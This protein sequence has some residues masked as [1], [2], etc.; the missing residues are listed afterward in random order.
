MAWVRKQEAVACHRSQILSL[1]P[2]AEDAPILPVSELSHFR[3]HRELV[4]R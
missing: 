1:G 4:L 2:A 3:R